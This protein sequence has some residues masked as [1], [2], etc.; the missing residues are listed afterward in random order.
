MRC[1]ASDV[2]SAPTG[3]PPMQ[4]EVRSLRYRWIDA[5]VTLHLSLNQLF[6]FRQTQKARAKGSGCGG[7]SIVHWVGC[8]AGRTEFLA[9][10]KLPASN[11]LRQLQS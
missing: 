5:D 6:H 2:C 9:F 3:L 11:C 4:T 8:A 7:K 10:G 1:L